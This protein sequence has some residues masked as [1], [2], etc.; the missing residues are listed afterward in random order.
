M[1]VSQV[2]LGPET[3]PVMA[4]AAQIT[5]KSIDVVPFLYN[6]KSPLL[7]PKSRGSGSG[8]TQGRIFCKSQVKSEAIWLL[9]LLTDWQKQRLC[10]LR[11]HVWAVR[12]QTNP[13]VP[14]SV[15]VWAACVWR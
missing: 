11:V 7:S 1:S 12:A 9:S 13:H 6:R 2:T 5:V 8:Q 15:D 4:V 3:L 14:G 10:A